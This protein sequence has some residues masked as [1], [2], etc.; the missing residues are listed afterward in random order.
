MPGHQ[1]GML[2]ETMVSTNKTPA[3]GLAVEP[4][5]QIQ[6][7]APPPEEGQPSGSDRPSPRLQQL[8]PVSLEMSDSENMLVVA[9][10]CFLAGLIS[11]LEEHVGQLKAKGKTRLQQ[12]YA[13]LRP[14]GTKNTSR[15]AEMHKPFNRYSNVLAYDHSRVPLKPLPNGLSA[16]TDYINANYLAGGPTAGLASFLLPFLHPSIFSFP[17]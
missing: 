3:A 9:Q 2:Q 8:A 1:G 13:S 10:R 5:I 11:Q 15:V 14:I 4:L 17:I 6:V 7:A 16:G 12:E